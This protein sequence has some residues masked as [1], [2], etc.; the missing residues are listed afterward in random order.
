MPSLYRGP[1]EGIGLAARVILH[2]SQLNRMGPNDVARLDSTQQ[3]MVTAFGVRQSS[4]GRVLQH[5]LAGEVVTVE[6]RFVADANRRMKVYRL[7]ALGESTARTLGR[8]RAEP[9]PPVPKNDWVAA[10]P[11]RSG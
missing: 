8:R 7:T 2:L 6:R 9:P 3:G 11:V 5:L 10:R 1:N 4:L